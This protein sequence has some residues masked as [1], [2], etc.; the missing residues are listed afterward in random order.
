MQNKT[1]TWLKMEIHSSTSNCVLKYFSTSRRVN[2]FHDIFPPNS[3]FH[4]PCSS[5]PTADCRDTS[6][7]LLHNLFARISALYNDATMSRCLYEWEWS[8]FR[9]F[10]LLISNLGWCL[11][12]QVWHVG[13]MWKSQPACRI[14]ILSEL[15]W[16]WLDEDSA[17]VPESSDPAYRHFRLKR[18]EMKKTFYQNF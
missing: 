1:A 17:P 5:L 13:S 18:K 10:F 2:I 9:L 8:S 4:D 11:H 3:D 14:F 16:D 15:I 12:Q 7:L 6:I